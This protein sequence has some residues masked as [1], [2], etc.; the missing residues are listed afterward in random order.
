V[1]NP[2]HTNF[3]ILLL[4]YNRTFLLE[5]TL[6]SLLAQV[7]PASRICVLDNGSTDD[8]ASVVKPF[9]TRGVEYVKR[10]TN[11][12][13]AA[14]SELLAMARGP[15][16]MLF[17]DDDL[18]HPNYLRDVSAA[19]AQAPDA[20]VVVS[21]MRAY[22]NPES[23]EWQNPRGNRYRILAGRQLAALLYGGFPMP[24]CSA[25]YRTDVLRKGNMH[26]ETLGK[27]SDRP[28]VID[29]ALAGNAVVMLDS[30]VKYRLHGGQDSV[31]QASGPF[32]PEIFALQRYYRKILGEK[33]S[34]YPG[35]IFLRRNYRNLLREYERLNRNAPEPISQDAFFRKA[36]EA[37]AASIWSLKYGKF[38]AA[39]TQVPRGIERGIKSIVRRTSSPI[40]A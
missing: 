13:R 29:S 1:K 18:L 37:G 14:W 15:W 19:L 2:I 4:T 30:Y 11:D 25:V 40:K 10:S 12:Q 28:F 35:R 21:A 6:E 27:I 36:I 5:A 22:K 39:L 20:S 23:V 38:Y 31:D 3:E 9:L 33:L 7:L 32:L 16:T 8:T 17:H 34:D 26:F 24:F